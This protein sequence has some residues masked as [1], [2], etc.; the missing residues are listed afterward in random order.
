MRRNERNDHPSNNN[1]QD[2][3]R[4]TPQQQPPPPPPPPPMRQIREG[5][6][7]IRPVPPVD[8]D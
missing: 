8:E 6:E 7:I 2:P 4:P 5:F 1:S 3:N